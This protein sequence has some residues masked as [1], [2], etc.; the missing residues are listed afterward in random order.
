MHILRKILLLFLINISTAIQAQ[1]PVFTKLS[2]KD[3]LPDVEFY[4]V[5]EDRKGFIWLAADKGLFRYDGKE[6][7]NYSHPDKRGLSVFGLKLDKEGRVWCNNISGQFFYIENDTLQL[8]IDIKD[9]LKNELTSFYFYKEN[10]VI[11]HFREVMIVDLKSKKQ[12][13][14]I[15]DNDKTIFTF[16]ANDSLFYTIEN[17]KYVTTTGESFALNQV[18][19]NLH[20]DLYNVSW[21]LFSFKDKRIFLAREDISK[22]GKIKGNTMVEEKKDNLIQIQL[23]NTMTDIPL[24]NYYRYEN[25]IWFATENGVFVCSYDNYKFTIRDHFFKGEKIS[26]IIKDKNNNYWFT[27]LNNGIYIIPNIHLKEFKIDA[28][29][30][31]VTAIS[32]IAKDKII[33][34]TSE[35]TLEVFDT[36]TSERI[37]L[38]HNKKEKV[39]AITPVNKDKAVISLKGFTLLLD[40][41][42]FTHENISSKLFPGVKDFSVV[43]ENK[44]LLACYNSA[45]EVSF[46]HP[47][48]KVIQLG[49]KRSYTAHY[50]SFN[51]RRYIGYV[52][53]IRAYDENLNEIKILNESKEI[54]T[55]DITETKDGTVW[56]S[57][58]KKGIFGVRGDSIYINY[59]TNN[60]LLSNLTSKVEGDGD[61]L[62]IATNNG[63]QVFNTKTKKFKNLTRQDGINTYN[64]SGIIP[65]KNKLF[66]SS[67]RGV[68]QVDKEKV[69]KEKENLSFYFTK[70]LVNDTIVKLKKHY[71][72]NHNE[73]KLE[74]NF[75]NNGFLSQENV[76]YAYKLSKGKEENKW[77]ILDKNISQ[78]TFNN[79]APGSYIFDLKAT[80]LDDTNHEFLK[81]VRF[82]I[83]LPF[84]KEWW[85]IFSIFVLFVS[86]LWYRFYKRLENIKRKQEV[87]LEKERLQKEL[88]STKLETLR[89]QMNPHFTFNALNSIQNLILKNDKQEAYNY[90]TKFSTLIREN[91]HLSTQDFVVFEQELSLINRYLELEKLRFKDSFVYHIIVGENVE[92]IKIPTMIIQPYVENA[93]KHGL[94]HKKSGVKK[95]RIEFSLEEGVLVSKII[96]NGIGIERSKEIKE[97]NNIKRKSFSTKSIQERLSFLRDY[98]KTDI[99]VEYPEVEI[100]TTVIIKIPYLL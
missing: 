83:A 99:G 66:F 49:N 12:I 73:N 7:K 39:F 35:G 81:T 82:T 30:I 42:D 24:I 16:I 45:L 25:L 6:F 70:V 26:K 9:Q 38:E 5:L 55:T 14:R 48:N 76:Q 2:E 89:S 40:L 32:K 64:I 10:L 78:V 92:E 84:Y 46:N 51:E 61:N 57:T 20:T 34:G 54:F 53:G 100:G 88:V 43:A 33:F 11:H 58:F 97:V 59:N 93:I 15:R 8:F 47:K 62:W 98:Y 37:R 74:F 41:K 29:N 91:L 27:T 1:H 36:N 90:L 69:F 22:R 86:I 96:D 23:P 17:K 95:I 18:Y 67:N 63:I 44:L 75:H 72:F 60:G 52:D 31:N 50:S 68:F 85:F 21:K 71:K 28:N 94:L 80:A 87:A 3:G 56:L 77:N 79:L 4:D 65:F 19:K 13:K